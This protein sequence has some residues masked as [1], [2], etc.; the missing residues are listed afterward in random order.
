MKAIVKYKEGDGFIDLREVEEPQPG[1]GEVK[2]EV[3]AA[4]ICGSDL[5]ILRGDIGIPTKLPVVLG[6]EYSGIIAKL[7]KGVTGWK[8]GQRVTA[9]NSREVCGRC[10]YCMRGHYNLCPERLATGYAFDGA[11]AAY[12]ISP[13]ERLH[14]LPETVDFHTGALSDPSAC[15]YRA[16]VEMAQ[17]QPGDT[18]LITGPGPMGLFCTQYATMSGA[19][20][21]ITGTGADRERIALA[22]TLGADCGIDVDASPAVIEIEEFTEGRGVDVVLECAGAPEAARLGLRVVKRRGRFVQVGIF[23]KTVEVDLDQVVLK[24]LFVTGSFS[25]KYWAWEKA[26][27]LA[28][29]GRMQARPLITDVLSLSD[30]KQGFERFESRKAIKVVFEPQRV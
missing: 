16:T 2:I 29:K 23:G 10:E 4:G 27:D 30:W 20:V 28:A 22:R 12:C 3:H 13:Q 5:H 19:T 15:A 11:F 9:E 6:H 17:V 25:Q 7:G 26:I 8:E 1:P 14:A 21:I 18:V 24:E